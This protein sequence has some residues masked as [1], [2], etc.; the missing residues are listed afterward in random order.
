MTNKPDQKRYTFMAVTLL[1]SVLIVFLTSACGKVGNS[2][3]YHRFPEKSWAR[4]NLLSFEMPVTKAD[5]YNIYLFA[6]FTPEFQYETLDFNMI[7]NTPSGEE[8]I[9]E[10]RM[11][12]KSKSGEFC[13]DCSKD[14]CEGTILLKKEL[15][16][17]K[18]GILK[19]EIENLA[20]RTTVAG[21]LGIGIRVVPSGK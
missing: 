16:L 1:V 2:E 3:L 17:T 11:P 18:P 4:F 12:V 5:S 20:P 15:H 7:M 21:V 19:I 8:R 10:Y 13:I 9:K 14:S 6:R